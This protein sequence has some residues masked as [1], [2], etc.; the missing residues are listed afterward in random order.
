MKRRWLLYGL[1]GIGFY[2]VF[3]VITAPAV[4]MA[5]TLVR[6]S[7]GIVSLN[8]AEGSVWRGRGDLVIHNASSP[9]QR[10]GAVRWSLNP[11]S[12]LAGQVRSHVVLSGP[13]TEVDGVVHLGYRHFAFSDFKAS[14][15]AQLVAAF[16]GPA[17]LLSPSG[18]VRVSTKEFALGRAGARGNAIVQ[19]QGAGSSLSSVQPL[20]DYRLSMEGS[21]NTTALQLETVS[22][23]LALS[24]QGQLHTE[25]GQLR[26]NGVAKPV[27]HAAELEP[28]LRLV[29]PD[30]GGGQRYL[31]INTLRLY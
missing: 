24:G 19:W 12:L 30:H 27:A 25:S 6:F 11:L 23:D 31:I 15:P 5:W 4:W 8:Q 2:S 20:G 14:F 10:L 13:G 9:P 17:A 18:Q 16:Y 3:L 29:G 7:H 21:G 1:L 28:L 22:G 26:F